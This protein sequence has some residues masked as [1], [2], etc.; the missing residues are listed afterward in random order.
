MRCLKVCLWITAVSCLAAAVCMVL[1]IAMMESFFEHFGVEPLPDTPIFIY[2]TRL[3]SATYTVIGVFLII[4]ALD[5]MKYGVMVPFAGIST[6]FIGLVCGTVGAI[7][8]MPK[9]WF[10][11]DA[12]GGIVLGLLIL[13]SWQK[14]KKGC[15]CP[16]QTQPG[17][18]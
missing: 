5:P 13:I 8:V 1:P 18:E 15:G 3:V 11:G 9:L 10:I 7:S 2:I 16:A 4:L 14:A 12:L 6:L 17:Q